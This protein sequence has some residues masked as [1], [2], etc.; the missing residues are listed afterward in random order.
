MKLLTII[1]LCSIALIA[2][3]EH[4]IN[5]LPMYGGQQ[6]PQV[7]RNE[8]SSRGAAKLGWKYFYKG[9]LAT[10]MKRFNQAWM[11]DR[12]NPEA[13]W[14]FGL[15]MGR[16][17]ESEDPE[18]CLRESIKFLEIAHDKSP[19]NA[20]ITS[21]LAFSYT[22]L[23]HI[24]QNS[25]RDASSD[26]SKAELLFKEARDLEPEYPVTLSNWSVL[27]FYSR[28]ILAARKLLSEAKS[29]GFTPNP[30]YEKKLKAQK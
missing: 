13:Y 3:A 12:E 30:E 4:A 20:R 28:D 21:D 24:F 25:K 7:D 5:E 9:D 23:G 22:L 11:F 1:T 8:E 26:F 29:K 14:G 6:E 15:I 17:S 2:K 16:R 19:K 18:V 10:A 27:K